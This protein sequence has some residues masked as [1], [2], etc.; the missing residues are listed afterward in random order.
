MDLQL[1]L[2]RMRDEAKELRQDYE[3]KCSKSL[4][5]ALMG[6]MILSNTVCKADKH[7]VFWYEKGKILKLMLRPL[8]I[9]KETSAV[10]ARKTTKL[11]TQ[12]ATVESQ[13][14]SMSLI[15]KKALVEVQALNRRVNEYSQLGIGGARDEVTEV[16]DGFNK[17]TQQVEID[18]REKGI[19]CDRVSANIDE[20]NG[21]IARTS[22]AR[23]RASQAQDSAT[24]ASVL[25]F[26]GAIAFGIT[27]FF[28]PPVALVAAGA[29]AGAAAI[30]TG[31]TIAA[32]TLNNEINQLQAVQNQLSSQLSDLETEISGLRD[33]L[34]ELEKQRSHYIDA[35]TSVKTL[36]SECTDLRNGAGQLSS[37]LLQDRQLLSRVR[38]R[39]ERIASDLRSI[40][41][42]KTRRQIT[43]RLLEI[44]Q[45]L[46]QVKPTGVRNAKALKQAIGSVRQIESHTPKMLAILEKET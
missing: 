36:E 3:Q 10:V 14:E 6:L 25:S 7:V 42:T 27:S 13:F 4:A 44:L 41:Y 26:G 38:L 23:D 33:Q 16:L 9:D 21:G 35:S 15:S 18:I 22:A 37:R 19:E 45:D 31:T 32:V 24:T 39:A 17:K 40:E 28:C 43:G 30:G 5:T 29:A 2:G 12:V 8:G 1:Q 20:T 46:G 11:K 34:P